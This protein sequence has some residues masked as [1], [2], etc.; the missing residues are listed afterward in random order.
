M[1]L[2]FVVFTTSV[3]TITRLFEPAMQK[4]RLIAS[5]YAAS[6]PVAAF[7]ESTGFAGFGV[8]VPFCINIGGADVAALPH[9]DFPMPCGR[10]GACAV[11]RVWL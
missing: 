10:S 6:S 11:P 8:D 3:R 4:N 1:S 2:T 7:L 9:R 5:C